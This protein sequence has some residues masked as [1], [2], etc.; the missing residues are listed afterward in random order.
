MKIKI[1]FFETSK[2]MDIRA[3]KGGVYK[4]ELVKEDIS[5]CLYVGESIWIAS[6]CGQ[7]LYSVMKKPEH[8]GLVPEDI[9][10]DKLTLKFSIVSKVDGKKMNGGF[11]KY[12]KSEKEAIEENK[13]LTQLK[14]SDRQI[15]NKVDMVQYKMKELGFKK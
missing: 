2:G 15:R 7:H 8:F 4:V 6:R 9:N 12:K 13:P 1:D 10:N 5:I 3:A 14:T 11:R